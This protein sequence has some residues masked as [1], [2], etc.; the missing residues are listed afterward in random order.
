M[1]YISPDITIAIFSKEADIPQ[2]TLSRSSFFMVF[3]KIEGITPAA[4]LER[5]RGRQ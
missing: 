1:A 4:W 3:K 5:E 2:K